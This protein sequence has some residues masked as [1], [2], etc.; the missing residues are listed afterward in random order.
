MASEVVPCWLSFLSPAGWCKVR[1]EKKVIKCCCLKIRFVWD[2]IHKWQREMHCSHF[3]CKEKTFYYRDIFLHLHCSHVA[4]SNKVKENVVP[5]TKLCVGI[6]PLN[7]I[8]FKKTPEVWVVWGDINWDRCWN[9]LASEQGGQREKYPSSRKSN[10]CFIFYRAI[11]LN[12]KT[13]AGK[14]QNPDPLKVTSVLLFSLVYA[15]QES[16]GVLTALSKK[17]WRCRNEISHQAALESVMRWA[18]PSDT[19]VWVYWW[20]VFLLHD[21]LVNDLISCC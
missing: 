9:K 1:Q 20:V 19:R 8:N 13:W 18:V 10:S 2:L 15:S 3:I 11:A 7:K 14:L 12:S 5:G 17:R 21:S 6:S 4:Q 16:P